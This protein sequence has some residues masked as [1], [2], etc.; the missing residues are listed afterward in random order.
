ME[1]MPNISDEGA[2]LRTSFSL[3]TFSATAFW[4]ISFSNPEI[5]FIIKFIMYFVWF[6]SDTRSLPRPALT[7]LPLTWSQ[8]RR[9]NAVTWYV[10]PLSISDVRRLS[11]RKNHLLNVYREREYCLSPPGSEQGPRTG[12][13]T[14]GFTWIRCHDRD[15][16]LWSLS[17]HSKRYWLINELKISHRFQMAAKVDKKKSVEGT[18]KWKE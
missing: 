9:L 8:S 13:Y 4:H 11:R 3:S 1:W 5:N 12:G 6:P 17:S 16:V 10:F 15:E 7:R 2:Q 18:L 14:G